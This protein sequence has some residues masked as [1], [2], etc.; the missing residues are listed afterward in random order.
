MSTQQFTYEAVTTAG[1]AAIKGTMEAPTSSAVAHK[2]RNQGLIPLGVAPV[3]KTGLNM[4][5][6]IPGLE[7]GV[8]PK[9][10]AIFARQLSTLLDAGLP[11]LRALAVVAEQTEDQR[12]REALT[13]VH[14]DVEG[15]ASF[16][17]ALARHPRIFPPLMV[18]MV[19]VSEMGG[20]LARSMRSVADTFAGEVELRQKV[21][22]A[23]T[24]PIVVACVAGVAVVVMM[25][26]VV[27]VFERMFK[28]MGATLPLPTRMLVA[29]S[30]SMVWVLPL[31]V[32]AVVGGS[33]WWARH[34][35][36]DAVRR[37]VD[38]LKL[39]LPV[40]GSLN[41]KIAISRFA[42]NLSMMLSAGVPMLQ[43]LAVVG[44]AANNTVVATAVDDVRSSMARGR[45]F[46]GPLA[47]HPVFPGMVAQM[48]AVGEESGS[49][50]AMM[51]AIGDFYD[52]E[53]ETAAEQ[54]SSSIEPLMILVLGVVIGGMVVALYLPMFSLYSHLQQQ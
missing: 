52:K 16:S 2:L 5:I 33:I 28:G 6:R 44:Q 19:R 20:F 34:R 11:L 3:S 13:T 36:D 8:K 41:Q 43:A 4:E 24:Y 31:L 54:L 39:R 21:R 45:S 10:L 26:F 22:G 30:H 40:F 18:N 9:A 1:G 47:N 49:L 7:R 38:P 12:L 53:V 15:G 35:F 32:L 50:G 46:A 48:A 37:T 42:R 27:P 25:L 29:V 23:M 14:A 51:D 17:I